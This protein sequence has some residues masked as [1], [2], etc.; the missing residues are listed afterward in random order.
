M[1]FI[2]SIMQLTKCGLQFIDSR[3]LSIFAILQF[4]HLR[5]QMQ[6]ILV[7]ILG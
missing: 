1:K 6:S 3:Y 2:R 7:D 5:H 4:P